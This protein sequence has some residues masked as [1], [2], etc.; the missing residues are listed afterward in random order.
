MVHSWLVERMAEE[1]RR[2]LTILG[3]AR[4]QLTTRDQLT[5]QSQLTMQ[6]AATEVHMLAPGKPSASHLVAAPHAD[7]A[8]RL[9]TPAMRRPVG[10]QVGT[11]LI[12]LGTRLGGASIRTS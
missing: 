5:T 4:H 10:H 11:L 12:R 1:H 6:N 3:A 7:P 2:D 9:S 8:M